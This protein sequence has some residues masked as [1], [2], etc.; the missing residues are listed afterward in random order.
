MSKVHSFPPIVSTASRVLILGTMPGLVSLKAREYYAHPRNAF[1]QI[2]GELFGA[3]PSLPYDERV[4]RVLSVGVALWDSLQACVRPGSM[5]KSIT[6]EVAN[7][8][9]A[10]FARYPDIGH[11][12]FNGSKSEAVFCRHALPSLAEGR[13][14]TRLP[15]TSPAHA[16]MTLQAKLHAWSIV[17]QT[18]SR[19]G[20]ENSRDPRPVRVCKARA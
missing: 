7:D 11:V 4:G 5:D 2:M 8:F 10:F 15:S 18:L 12:F 9:V 16:G 13:V 14:Y 19:C 6:G 20:R 3:G 1:W 17:A